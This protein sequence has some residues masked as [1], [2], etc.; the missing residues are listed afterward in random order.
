MSGSANSLGIADPQ[1]LWPYVVWSM[2][3]GVVLSAALLLS[4]ILGGHG[5]EPRDV[6]T[7]VREGWFPVGGG[8]FCE[9]QIVGAI[10]YL[11]LPAFVFFVIVFPLTLVGRRMFVNLR[12]GCRNS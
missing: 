7:L 10:V 6:C 11:A 9:V 5:A 12:K 2:V 8:L 3:A 4:V 1:R